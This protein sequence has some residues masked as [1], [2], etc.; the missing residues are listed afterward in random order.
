M[1]KTLE[2]IVDVRRPDS[3]ILNGAWV[4]SACVEQNGEI[5]RRWVE[6]I[7]MSGLHCGLVGWF[8]N[9]KNNIFNSDNFHQVKDYWNTGYDVAR[10]FSVTRERPFRMEPE[11][12][13]WLYNGYS[14][15]SG[16]IQSAMHTGN[17]NV[18]SV[19]NMIL[20]KDG[21]I[22]ENFVANLTTQGNI[23]DLIND[24]DLKRYKI[25]FNVGNNKYMTQS[26]KPKEVMPAVVCEQSMKDSSKFSVFV[27]QYLEIKDIKIV[28]EGAW[29]PLPRPSDVVLL[30]TIKDNSAVLE[31]NLTLSAENR[32]MN[33]HFCWGRPNK[34]A[35]AMQNQM[36]MERR[37]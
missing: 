15:K 14:P 28:I 6:R 2:M 29:Q 11:Y 34:I 21:C 7:Q 1:K 9:K 12:G 3:T 27:P 30:K 16:W 18:A 17:N 37:E 4:T 20:L 24:Y 33:E 8:D 19:G 22:K 10:V 26:D 36:E 32:A 35:H 31:E 23:H 25:W 13:Y 5:K